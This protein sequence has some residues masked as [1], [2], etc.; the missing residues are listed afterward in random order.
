MYF[1]GIILFSIVETLGITY[2]LNKINPGKK[3]YIYLYGLI[4]Y[5]IVIIFI[6]QILN[7][8]TSIISSKAT[9]ISRVKFFDAIINK[10]STSYKDI[11]I[12]D[13]IN[14]IMNSTLEMKFVILDITTQIIPQMIVMISIVILVF[15]F[16]DYKIGFILLGCLLAFII[17]IYINGDKI[18]F[19]KAK[20]ED[21]F[22]NVMDDLNNKYSNLLNTYIN[23]ENENEKKKIKTKQ[24]AYSDLSILAQHKNILLSTY[25]YILLAIC[26]CVCIYIF[27]KYPIQNKKLF[28]IL[29]IYF[30]INYLTCFKI[31]RQVLSC[32]GVSLGSYDFLNDLLQSNTKITISNIKKG[33]IK[34]TNLC[35]GYNKKQI[36]KNINLEIKNNEKIALIGKSG[37]GKTT[38]SKLLLKLH[39]YKGIIKIDNIDIQKIDNNVLRKKI[40]YINQRTVLFEKSVIDNINYGNNIDKN[41]I[42]NFLNKYEL[43]SIFSNLQNGINEKIR[44]NGGNLSLGM[45]KI[46]LLVR[47]ILKSKHSII[48]VIDEPLASLDQKTIAKVLKMLKNECS[49]KTLLI[50]THDKEIYPIVDRIIDINDLNNSK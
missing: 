19:L 35:F 28:I 22:Y 41:K 49:N 14:R 1:I 38:L 33:D 16:I 48:V 18:T 31:L 23:N 4:L 13:Y 3:N 21:N 42:I 44:V 39:E 5:F 25:L 29:I 37:S 32:L 11:E 20:Q 17:L 43:T 30:I 24:L 50:I 12:G 36:L 46:I 45:Q 34:I 27:I 7:K 26:I 40:T 2:L 10:Y 15:L 8:Y 9:E 47:G 6:N